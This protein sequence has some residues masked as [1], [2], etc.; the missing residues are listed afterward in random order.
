MLKNVCAIATPR[1]PAR[2]AS[3]RSAPLPGGE[4]KLVRRLRRRLPPVEEVKSRA[5]RLRSARQNGGRPEA[6]SRSA[7]PKLPSFRLSDDFQDAEARAP[8]SY[9]RYHRR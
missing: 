9:A 7:R 5:W 4:R 1:S 2:S 3:L 6:E 8:I